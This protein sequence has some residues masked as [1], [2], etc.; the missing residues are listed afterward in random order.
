[1]GIDLFTGRLKYSVD[2]GFEKQQKEL[3]EVY[4]GLINDIGI[5]GRKLEGIESDLGRL[6]DELRDLSGIV[7]RKLT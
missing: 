3:M 5:N 4:T 7:N 6:Q 1:V 2:S